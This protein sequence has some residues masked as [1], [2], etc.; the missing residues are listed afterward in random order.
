MPSKI[1]NGEFPHSILLFSLENGISCVYRYPLD[2]KGHLNTEDKEN[3]FLKFGPLLRVP[4]LWL[5]YQDW[6]FNFISTNHL[7]SLVNR[8]IDFHWKR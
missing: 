8:L 3:N 1:E 7:I 6:K 4:V 2:F 5:G